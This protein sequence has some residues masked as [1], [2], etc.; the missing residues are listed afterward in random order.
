L[1]DSD[2]WVIFE[3]GDRLD[4]DN[5]KTNDLGFEYDEESGE[6]VEENVNRFE[7]HTESN[8][9][10]WERIENEED[11]IAFEQM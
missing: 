2:E 6:R 7:I 3:D 8:S 1:E 10:D 5:E 9:L 4:S 11:T